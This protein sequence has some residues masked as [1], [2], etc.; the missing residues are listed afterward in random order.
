MKVKTYCISVS[1]KADLVQV[2]PD[3]IAKE[4]KSTN[5]YFL[6]DSDV[7]TTIVRIHMNAATPMD[8]DTH[9]ISIEK[10]KP[11]GECEECEDEPEEDHDSEQHG[12]QDEEGG[13]ICFM[14]WQ[15]KRQWKSGV[16]QSMLQL[17][18]NGSPKQRLLE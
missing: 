10:E 4:L 16:R 15:T 13:P 17:Q 6:K 8:V 11:Q 18:G 14:G 9:I 7:V 3:V 12:Y 5:I 2:L 1:K